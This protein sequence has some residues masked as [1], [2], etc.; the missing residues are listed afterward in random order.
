VPSH[1]VAHREEESKQDHYNEEPAEQ[2]AVA[3]HK[4]KFALVILC[5][6]GY[7]SSFETEPRASASGLGW[8]RPCPIF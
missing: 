8:G 6:K 7:Y 3:Q 2:L 5:H 1:D 4:L